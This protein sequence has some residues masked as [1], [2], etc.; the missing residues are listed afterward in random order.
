MAGEGPPS[1]PLVGHAEGVDGDLRRHRSANVIARYYKVTA[2][3][4]V[5]LTTARKYSD[6]FETIIG[7]TRY[8]CALREM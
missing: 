7:K 4:S 6:F 5:T 3:S 8:K 1:T 2:T